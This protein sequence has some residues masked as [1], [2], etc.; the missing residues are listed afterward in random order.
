M[1][2]KIYTNIEQV[3]EEACRIAERT[4]KVVSLQDLEL[5]LKWYKPIDGIPEIAPLMEIQCCNDGEYYS[6]NYIGIGCKVNGKY[7]L[8]N[9]TRHKKYY[10]SAVNRAEQGISCNELRLLKSQ[11]TQPNYIGVPTEKKLQNWAR[12][13]DNTQEEIR[14]F[15]RANRSRETEE[16]KL[17]AQNEGAEVRRDNNGEI[18]EV[19]IR[20]GGLRFRFYKDCGQV[21]QRHTE[22]YS[23]IL[24][25]V[26]EMRKGVSKKF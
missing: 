3:R 15:I 22:N 6:G 5:S 24:D 10:L 4:G 14:N 11:Y 9:T 1:E 23:V 20:R 26:E 17:I 13:V 7:Y 25:M 2:R 19:V 18:V 12:Y 8:V 16:M 21:Y